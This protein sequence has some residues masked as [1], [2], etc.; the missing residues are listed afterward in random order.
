MNEISSKYNILER[1]GDQS[2]RKFGEVFLVQNKETQIKGVLKTIEKKKNN[3]H[4]T[5]RLRQEALF[6]FDNPGLPKTIDFIETEKEVLL[7][8]SYSKGIQLDEYWKKI[9]RKDRLNT[10]TKIIRSLAEQLDVL[11]NKN[12]VHCDIKP[13]N[14]VIEETPSGLQTHLIDFGMAIKLPEDFNRTTLFPL[15]FA[16]PELILNQYSCI[17]HTSDLFSLGILSW[18]LFTGKLP[19]SNSN[20]GIYTNLQITHPLPD[21]TLLPKGIFPVLSKMCHKHSFSLPPN[22]LKKEE[23]IRFLK[24]AN[25]QRYQT[26][27]EVISDIELIQPVK[28]KWRI[29]F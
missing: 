11:R 26:I 24:I 29:R 27:Q 15:G 17:D 5:D 20:P 21:S 23:V 25:Q 22:Q 4:L 13:S 1:L 10:W 18:L 9:Q 2:K 12:I 3:Q 19:L 6:S 8:K 7:I 28:K 14:I 16:S